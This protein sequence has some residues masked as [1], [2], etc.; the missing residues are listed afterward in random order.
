MSV[1][2]YWFP[3]GAYVRVYF[4]NCVICRVEWSEIRGKIDWCIVLLLI[5]KFF[6]L[7]GREVKNRNTAFI[8]TFLWVKKWIR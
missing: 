6:F 3:L 2:H 4:L 8:T 1:S 7:G 5:H